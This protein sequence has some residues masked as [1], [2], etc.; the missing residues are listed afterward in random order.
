MK[1]VGW[2]VAVGCPEDIL[3]EERSYTAKFLKGLLG[4]KAGARVRDAA[5]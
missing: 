1:S 3:G 5:E 4:R 2:I